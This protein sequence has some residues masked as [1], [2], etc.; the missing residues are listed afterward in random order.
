MSAPLV[1]LDTETTG[2][3]YHDEIWEIA[4]IR[5]ETDGTEN[6]LHLLVDHDEQL[7]AELPEPF[8]SD[9]MER[10]PL[11]DSGVTSRTDASSLVTGFLRPTDGGDGSKA[12]IVGAVPNFDT[13]RL[14]RMCRERGVPWPAHHHLVD[15]ENLT[16]G[17]LAAITSR[18]RLLSPDRLPSL[19]PPWDSNELSAAV[20]VDPEQFARHTA[21]GDAEWAMAIYD[22]VMGGTR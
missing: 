18:P 5:R 10:W 1:F 12:H 22:R 7:C 21:M 20:G 17:F 11:N 3:A 8:L 4:A 13:E 6:R 9:H 15:V 14:Q 16:V 2:L 19:Q